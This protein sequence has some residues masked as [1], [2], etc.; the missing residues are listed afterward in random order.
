VTF[1]KVF[2]LLPEGRNYAFCLRREILQVFASL[3][4]KSVLSLLGL[5]GGAHLPAAIQLGN[6]LLQGDLFRHHTLKRSTLLKEAS[7]PIPKLSL[8]PPQDPQSLPDEPVD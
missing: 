4:S 5:D 8:L 2:R 6:L 1:H 3:L 7:E